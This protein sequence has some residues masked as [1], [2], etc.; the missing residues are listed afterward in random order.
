MTK[1]FILVDDHP[2][3][4][5]GICIL[6]AQELGLLCLGEASTI[7][8]ARI[9]LEK[10]S[11]DIAIIDLSLQNENGLTLVCECKANHPKTGVLV[12]S[13]H[14]ENLY[15]ERSIK[16]GAR[17]YVMKH[18]DPQVLL[19]AVR[20]ILHGDLAISANLKNRLVESYAAGTSIDPSMD[21]TGREFEIFSLI[22]KGYG[23][24]DIANELNLSTKTVNSYQ[25]RIKCKLGLPSAGQLR[26]F[27]V[28]WKN[29]DSSL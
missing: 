15:G 9:L 16:A 22:G 11:P 17:G 20:T 7:S 19:E 4:R 29:D 3:Y 27:A 26:R 1:T 28:E 13:M 10:F 25:D 14:D 18:E 23:A 21:L 6:I 2:L 12:V 8:E 24:S 5:S